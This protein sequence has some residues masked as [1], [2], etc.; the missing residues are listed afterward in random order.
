MLE[1]SNG[2]KITYKVRLLTALVL[3]LGI[4]LVAVFFALPAY[5]APDDVTFTTDAT[6]TVSDLALTVVMGSRVASF[7]LNTGSIVFNMENGS[8]VSVLS[9]DKRALDNSKVGTSCQSNYS[10]VTLTSNTTETITVT[11]S[12][13]TAPCYDIVSGGVTVM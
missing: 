8:S 4:S 9:A 12:A 1:I 10:Y 13:S 6:F 7:T 5:A 11:P 2:L 3:G